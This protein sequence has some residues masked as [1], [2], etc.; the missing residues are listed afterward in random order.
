MLNGYFNGIN[1][2]SLWI[3]TNRGQKYRIFEEIHKEV[4]DYLIGEGNDADSIDGVFNFLENLTERL[5][6]DFD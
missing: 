2:Q 1:Q 5:Q 4:G 3:G 6:E